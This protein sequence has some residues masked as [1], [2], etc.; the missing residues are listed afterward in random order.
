MAEGMDW[1]IDSE[2]FAEERAPAVTPRL[3]VEAAAYAA[4]GLLAVALRFFQLGLRPLDAAEAEQALAA[5]RL[6]GGGIQAAPE[7]TLPALLTG[8]AASFTLFGAG[9]VSVRLLPALAG[10]LLALLPLGLRH[11]LGRGGALAASLLLALSPSAIY[12]SRRVDGAVL[13]AA[14]GLAL[15]VGLIRYIDFGRPRALY[16]AAAALGLGLAAGSGFYSW[17]LILALYG[18]VLYVG[19]RWLDWNTG[20]SS[21]AR[22]YEVARQGRGAGSEATAVQSGEGKGPVAPSLLLR[23]GAILVGVFALSATT[24]VL[25]PAGVGLAADLAATWARSFL[26]EP[27]GQPAI[28]PLLLLLLYEPLTLVLGLLAAGRW[29]TGRRARDARLPSLQPSLSHTALLLFWA[30]GATLLIILA[31]HRPATNVLIVIVP[32]ALLGGQ[33]LEST[34]RRIEGRARRQDVRLAT[35]VALGLAVFLYL[36]LAAFARASSSATVSVLGMTVYT[37]STY[38]FLALVALVLAMG[39]GVA[40]WIWRGPQVVAAAAWLAAVIILSLFTVK[41]AW[42]ANF[43]PDPRDLLVGQSTAPGVGLFLNQLEELS[44]SRSGDVHT[45]EVTV[46]AATG[47]V[48]AWYLRDFTRLDIVEGLSGP[49]ATGVAV[50]L[51]AA[52]LPIGEAFR[53]QA[54]PVRWHWLP[55]G[56]GGQDLMRWLLFGEG[57]LP[58]VDQEVVLWVSD[59]QS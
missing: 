10:L 37:T 30:L 26:P 18:A 3:T 55:W 59:T 32:L 51:A 49:P 53:G 52:D 38:L 24:F 23:A 19:Q 43:D 6:V 45:L 4:V 5:F 22:A 34:W 42:R 56:L 9:D 13:V 54:Y 14:F 40:A 27:G 36:Q 7:G 41:G 2:E 57:S 33:G 39:L 31:G 20:W 44:Q 21:L 1:L 12:A 48:I 29:L 47:P 15:V 25:H 50:T 16:L 11:R 17:L 58:T 28:Y 8:N 35:L 46:D